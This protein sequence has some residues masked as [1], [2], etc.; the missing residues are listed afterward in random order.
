VSQLQEIILIASIFL[1]AAAVQSSIGFGFGLIATPLL[2]WLGMSMMDVVVIILVGSFFQTLVGVRAH[3][4]HV[5]WPFTIKTVAIRLTFIVAGSFVLFKIAELPQAHIKFV[6]GA[7]TLF[8]V[9]LIVLNKKKTFSSLHAAWGVLAFSVSGFFAGL[10]G[11]GGPPLLVWVLAQDWS[12]N[13]SRGF[14]FSVYMLSIPLQLICLHFLAAQPITDALTKG[15]AYSPIILIGSW[16]GI[17]WGQHLNKDKFRTFVITGLIL[18]ALLS[19]I[20]ALKGN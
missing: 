16:L 7:L 14:L 9:A 8:M 3:L 12:P 6:V 11:I 19:I 17:K 18:I 15:C 2:I 20:S 5:D 10:C 1:G 13:K 4:R